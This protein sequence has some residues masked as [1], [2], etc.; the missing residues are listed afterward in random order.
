MK[1]AD[2][3]AHALLERIADGTYQAGTALPSESEIAQ[4]LGVSRLTVREAVRTL[5][6]DGVIDV[7]QGRRNRIAP[8]AQWSILSP[9]VVAVMARVGG[10][11]EKLLADLLES[12]LVLEVEIARMAAERISAEQLSTL[13]RTVETMHRTKASTDDDEIAENIAA[14]IEFHETVVA[15]ADNAYL[16]SIYRPLRQ[17]LTAV[18]QQT[19]MSSQV[20]HEATDWHHQIL[21]ALEARDPQAA[22]TAMAGHMHQTRQ[23]M[24]R[25]SLA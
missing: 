1:T 24:E 21:T 15:A 4:D 11:A 22:S 16:A 2:R 25:I 18:R 9:A 5:A 7:H 14:D 20:R 10:G 17:I 23:A 8:T 13:R 12:R 3:V 19:S 6:G